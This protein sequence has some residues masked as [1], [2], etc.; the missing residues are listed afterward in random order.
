MQPKD[1][2]FYAH[3]TCFHQA[4]LIWLE[5]QELS[6]TILSMD[7]KAPLPFALEKPLT[8]FFFLFIY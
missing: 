1:K 4:I 2:C 8:L 3:D 7:P 6:S 5:T